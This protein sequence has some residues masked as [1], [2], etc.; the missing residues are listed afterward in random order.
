[1]KTLCER[2][3]DRVLGRGEKRL[4]KPPRGAISRIAEQTNTAPQTVMRW[5]RG[6]S[7][8]SVHVAPRVEDFLSLTH[9]E[10][11]AHRPGPKKNDS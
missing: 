7:E 2:L 1:M 4:A 3:R 9:I 6:E 5:L 11:G 8:P 10:L